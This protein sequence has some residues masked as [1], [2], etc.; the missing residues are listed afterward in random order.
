VLLGVVLVAANPAAA[1]SP[2]EAHRFATQ[3][4]K[5]GPR[6]AGSQAERKAHQR[7]A[8]RFKAA[9]LRVGYERFRVPGHGTSRDVIGI[10][11]DTSTDCLVIAMAHTDSVPPAPGADDSGSGVGALVAL[12]R[13]LATSETACDVWLV[14]T[15]AEERPYTLQPD[16][17]GAS[18]LVR[19]LA[20]THRLED[21]KLA[22]SL[23][24]VG[25]GTRS[26]L[27]STARAP[28]ERVE[29]RILNAATEAK[30]TVRWVRDPAG[31]GN[32][33]HRELA[34]AGAPAAKLG[35]VDEPCRHTA[36]DTPDRLQR[37]AFTRV[38]AV[39][40]P[41]LRSWGP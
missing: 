20:R 17:L 15:G 5:A 27:H 38:L 13:P 41:L 28:R 8:Q 19:R 6:P 16:H 34:R 18:A 31:E 21:V 37:G 10:R 12:A 22:L 14:A 39:V 29:R 33:D 4:A 3:L 24:E 7:V 40:W 2:A 35:V 25:R 36:C 9:G 26:D 23:D 11:D 32:S 1:P 30:V